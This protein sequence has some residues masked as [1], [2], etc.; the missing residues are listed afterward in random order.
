MMHFTWSGECKHVE[1]CY[2]SGAAR[3]IR[4]SMFRKEIGFIG[5]LK[6]YLPVSRAEARRRA[7]ADLIRAAKVQVTRGIMLGMTHAIAQRHEPLEMPEKVWWK[8]QA[9]KW[10]TVWGMLNQASKDLS[11][12]KSLSELFRVAEAAFSLYEQ[13]TLSSSALLEVPADSLR[14]EASRWREIGTLIASL[15]RHCLMDRLHAA[16]LTEGKNAPNSGIT[17]V[18]GT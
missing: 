5:R 12:F 18:E 14:A 16:H 13:M 2:I 3:E 11:D 1:N 4:G 15:H 9:A 8:A 17:V 7:H 10:E 6:E